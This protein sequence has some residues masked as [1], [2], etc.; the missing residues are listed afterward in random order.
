MQEQQHQIKI[1][2][3]FQK[4][5]YGIVA[6]DCLILFFANAEIN[7]L[8]NLLRSFAKIGAFYPPI[9][10]K[11]STLVLI[12]LV[13][14]GTK[15]KKKRDLNVGKEIVIPIIAGLS[16]MFGSLLLVFGAEN[17]TL[18]HY[19]TLFERVPTHICTV[20]IHR[21]YDNSNGSGQYFQ[22]NANQNGKRPL[23][24]RRRIFRPK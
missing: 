11:I 20:I 1:Y 14:I 24:Y 5:V 16:M 19:S 22:T 3:F 8:S 10:A 18:P 4:V 21:S 15:A 9:N 13:A 17:I 12:A 7:I 23:E 2:D 6:L